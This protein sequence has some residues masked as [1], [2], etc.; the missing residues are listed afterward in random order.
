VA[1]PL[2]GGGASSWLGCWL[3]AGWRR[4]VVGRRGGRAGMSASR[5]SVFPRAVPKPANESPQAHCLGRHLHLFDILSAS[6]QH[7]LNNSCCPV[8]VART[9][10]AAHTGAYL[11]SNCLS[12]ISRAT[13]PSWIL[14]VLWSFVCRFKILC[15]FAC[16]FF[17]SSSAWY[18][19]WY[20]PSS[21]LVS[22]SC[23][24]STSSLFCPFNVFVN[25]TDFTPPEGVVRSCSCPRSCSFP[26]SLFY[27]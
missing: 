25:D 18:W 24:G 12:G 1:C 21:P 20:H 23:T 5:F 11:V 27:V 7:S 26:R 6:E 22:R 15:S 4:V 9:G 19:C 2:A 14:E 10:L 8:S 17:S 3:L 13:P 16:R